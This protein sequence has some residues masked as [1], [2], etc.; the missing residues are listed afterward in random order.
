[1]AI[2]VKSYKSPFEMQTMFVVSSF[3]FASARMCLSVFCH[4]CCLTRDKE[5]AAPGIFY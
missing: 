4:M 2:I 5:G 3:F 1:M